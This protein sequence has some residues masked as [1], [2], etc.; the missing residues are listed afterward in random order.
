MSASSVTLPRRLTLSGLWVAAI[1]FFTTRFTVTLAAYDQPSQFVLAGVVPLVLGLLLAIFGMALVVGAFDPT[2]VRTVA[3]WCT[4]GM[5][6]MFIL[7]VLTLLGSN[8]SGM[9]SIGSVTSK[10]YLSNFLI[11]GSILGTFIGLYAA[12]N[13]QHQLELRQ[14]ANRLVTLNRILRH[15]VLNAITVI[16]GST[17][18]IQSSGDTDE[19]IRHIEQKSDHV[20]DT[21][22]DVKYLTQTERSERGGLYPTDLARTVA[23]TVDTIRERYPEAAVDYSRSGNNGVK[24]WADSRLPHVLYHLA[25]N[26]IVHNDDPTPTVDIELAVGRDVACVRITDTGPGL[27]EDQRRI[28][29]EGD[30]P[31]RDDPRTGF[32]TNLARMFVERYGGDIST[33][34]TGEGTMIEVELRRSTESAPPNQTPTD[35]RSYGIEPSQLVTAVGSALV[36]GAAMG[37]VIQAMAGVVPVIGALYGVPDPFIGWITH[38][39]HSVVF[40]LIYAG[41]IVVVPQRFSSNVFGYVGIGLAWAT[42][43]WLFAAGV[44]MPTWQNLIGIQA[45][46]PHL[47]PPALVGHLIWGSTLGIVYHYGGT[48]SVLPETWGTTAY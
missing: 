45:P 9:G 19:P 31:E 22:E 30:I 27:P 21:I 44:V 7:V 6:S 20:V 24:V 15:E 4:V 25:E 38:E 33:E 36:A 11:G 48:L 34:Q 32:G 40:G 1:G 43:L 17:E 3:A 8:P 47:T 26:A 37:V 12:E 46:I 28:L 14:Q 35:V 42:F 16:R 23:D 13:S 39:F 10:V 2:Y 5:V 18:V 41:L 29:E